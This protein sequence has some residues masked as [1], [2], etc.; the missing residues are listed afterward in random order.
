MDEGAIGPGKARRI[1]R[2]AKRTG[3][4]KAAREGFL[5][6]LAMTCSV[7]RAAAHVGRA[8]SGAYRLRAD[9]PVFA[10][11]WRRA[12]ETGY[13]RLEALVLEHGGAGAPL[14][15]GE[16]GESPPGFDFERALQVLKYYRGQRD[17]APSGR[18]GRKRRNATREETNALLIK[19][20]KAAQKRLARQASADE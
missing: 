20:L 10:D 15:P 4:T 3:W 13:D 19:A 5:E 2:R 14:E 11:A 1:Q 9:D 7:I 17:G 16:T 8:P 18:T 6:H 12:I